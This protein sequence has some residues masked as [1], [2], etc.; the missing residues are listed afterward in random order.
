MTARF[1]RARVQ[2]HRDVVERALHVVRGGE[3]LARD[4][5]HAE[6]AVVGKGAAARRVDVVGGQP[7]AD[8]AQRLLPAVDER[9]DARPR[10]EIAVAGERLGDDDLARRAALRRAPAADHQLVEPRR[11][12]LRQPDHPADD[13]LRDAGDVQGH[14][15]HDRGFHVAHARDG[16]D[17]PLD[18]A[19][20]PLDVGEH[21]PEARRFVEVVACP[22]EGVVRRE[23]AGEAGERAGDDQRD[24]DDLALQLPQVAQQLAVDGLHQESS[25]GVSLRAFASTCVMRPSARCITRSAIP[26]IATLCVMTTAVVPSSTLIRAITSSTTLP[27]G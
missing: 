11:G 5:E 19:R 20:R 27:V 10:A 17:A 21:L 12:A 4:P 6:V 16:G 15:E 26:A 13:R 9:G 7:D 24:G 22:L 1:G 18:L 2:Q 14:V 23:R 25:D 3:P 8:D